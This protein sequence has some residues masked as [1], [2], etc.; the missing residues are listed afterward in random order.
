MV[1]KLGGN[2]KDMDNLNALLSWRELDIV[3]LSNTGLLKQELM[4]MTNWVALLS[5]KTKAILKV[6]LTEGMTIIVMRK[7]REIQ[8]DKMPHEVLVHTLKK[9]ASTLEQG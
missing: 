8:K 5:W 3:N 2:N 9:L 1:M 7:I 4:I 6:S